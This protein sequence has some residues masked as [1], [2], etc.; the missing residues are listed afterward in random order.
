MYCL[1]CILFSFSSRKISVLYNVAS[2]KSSSFESDESTSPISSDST[3]LL[4]VTFSVFSGFFC[5]RLRINILYGRSVTYN[6]ILIYSLS[7]FPGSLSGIPPRQGRKQ[8]ISDGNN[9][10]S[11]AATESVRHRGDLF[12]T[13]FLT[14]VCF[15]QSFS[16]YPLKKTIR[17]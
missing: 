13:D 1:H 11:E 12:T 3:G 16:C 4:I 9:A 5:L 6:N 15:F 17:N 10:A 2:C 7:T 14:S 8:E